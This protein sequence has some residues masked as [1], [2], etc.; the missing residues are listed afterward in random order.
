MKGKKEGF[1]E[2]FRGSI[3]LILYCGE[4]FHLWKKIGVTVLLCFVFVANIVSAEPTQQQQAAIQKA[5]DEVEKVRQAGPKELS[6]G[7]QG[8]LQLPQG[9]YYVPKTQ[10][11]NF[12]KAMGNGADPEMLGMILPSNDDE[13]WFIIIDY[14]ESG[15]IKDDDAKN[16][17]VEELLQSFKEG[18]EEGNKERVKKGFSE[19]EIIGWV[20]KPRYDA[21]NKRLIWSM[22][23]QKKG[24]NAPPDQQT[25]N[26]NAY[27][28]GRE[29]YLNLILVTNMEEV[30]A[31][32]PMVEQIL[33]ATQFVQ[34]KRY[35]EFDSSTDKVAEYGL[36]ALV[37][38]AAAKKLGFFA[39]MA[40][41]GLKFGKIIAVVVVAGG[42]LWAKLRGK[43]K[44]AQSPSDSSGDGGAKPP[45]L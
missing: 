4:V 40:A 19:L 45:E 17:D 36:A 31:Q 38:G 35:E 37:A 6:L 26:Y 28:L 39:L 21:V 12:M 29:G 11:D 32:K 16:W 24:A 14:I 8:K 30:N 27:V 9:F 23:S 15:Y 2:S 43:K 5:W 42:A 25:I 34:G 41:F 33:A 1:V 13:D 7:K 10:A 18:T 44:S 22:S 3:D 20:E